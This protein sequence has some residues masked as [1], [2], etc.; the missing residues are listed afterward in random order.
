MQVVGNN[1][2]LVYVYI[3]HGPSDVRRD[4]AVIIQQLLCTFSC[5]MEFTSTRGVVSSMIML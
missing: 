2:S 3:I 5:I 1:L 4:S